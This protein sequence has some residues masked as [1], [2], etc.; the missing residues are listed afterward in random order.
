[1]NRALCDHLKGQ[2]VTA[3][4]LYV[5]PERRPARYSSAGHPPP[6]AW[7]SGSSQVIPLDGGGVFLGFDPEAKYST[8]EVP[9]SRGER[10]LVYTDGLL[11][12]TN[13]AGDFLDRAG[14]EKFL[15][16]RGD[17]RAELFADALLGH[18]R[19]WSGRGGAG[20]LFED[21][22]TLVVIDITD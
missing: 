14:L 13:P 1:M 6:L 11:E 16:E 20:R 9:L 4:Y 21:D 7:Q 18:L 8:Y 3:S 22:L 17:L 12:I 2:F 19:Q 15:M 10:L 5:D